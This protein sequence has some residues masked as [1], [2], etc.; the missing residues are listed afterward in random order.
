MKS[1]GGI[2]GK[3]RIVSEQ[4]FIHHCWDKCTATLTNIDSDW[5]SVTLSGLVITLHSLRVPD[6]TSSSN[7]ILVSAIVHLT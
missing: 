3:E 7:I 1:G 2:A 4:E 6:L 5:M